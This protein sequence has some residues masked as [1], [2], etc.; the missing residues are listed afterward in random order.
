MP[1]APTP[2]NKEEVPC[3]S[4]TKHN[5][6]HPGSLLDHL[7]NVPS[8]NKAELSLDNLYPKY[9]PNPYLQDTEFQYNQLVRVN[10][11]PRVCGV[12]GDSTNVTTT[13]SISP[14]LMD[15]GA[16]ICITNKLELLVDIR[17][18]TPF[19][20]S[21]ATT[22]QTTLDG[23]CTMEGLLPL[24]L[25][26]GITI[27]V[28]TYY[29][30]DAAE[31][32]ISPELIVAS[33]PIYTTWSQTGYKDPT[34][35]GQLSLTNDDGTVRS[36]LTL[37]SKNNLYYCDSDVHT[38]Q[39]DILRS[40]CH[41]TYAP[42]TKAN[43]I[44]SELW[45]LRL[46]SPG[47]HQLDVL[48]SCA[49]GIPQK[50]A[51]HPFRSIDFKEQ[52]SIRKQP[53]TKQ[54]ERLPECG[55]E[56]YMDFGFMR[57][58]TSDYKKPN[59]QSDRVVLSHDGCCAYLII[60]DGKSRRLWAFT[61]KSK[62]PPI[63]LVRAFLAKFGKKSGGLIRTDQGG[64]LARCEEFR[65]VMETEFGY[66]VEPTGADS[67]SQNGAVE[68]Y[69]GVMGIRVR[70]LLYSSGLPAQFWSSALLHAAYLHNRQVHSATKMTPYEAWYGKRP[71]LAHLRVFGSRVCVRQPGERRCKLDRHDYSGIFLGYT[72]TD[73]NIIYLDTTSGIVKTS[74]HAVFD[75]SWYHQPKRPPAAQ[76]LYDIGLES[77]QDPIPASPDDTSIPEPVPAYPPIAP[78]TKGK[79]WNAPT[80]SLTAP[81]PLPSL[82]SNIISASA[83]VLKK[84]QPL[85]KLTGKQLA[86]ELVT[87]YLIGNNDTATIYM[88]PC[89][90]HQAFEEEL[91]LRK[92]DFSK[93]PTAGLQLFEKD[94]RVHLASMAPNSPGNKIYKWRTNVR[95]AWLMAIDNKQVTSISEVQSMIQQLCLSQAKSAV[96][97]FAHPEV[98]RDISNN[99][100]P[101]IH[102][103]DLSQAT[104]DQLNNRID[105]RLQRDKTFD[106]VE[107]GE[108][109]NITTKVMRL[110]RGKLLKQDDWEEWHQ[111]EYLQLD[112][113]D[114]QGMFGT[115]TAVSDTDSIF[116][117]VWTYN[118]KVVDGRKKARCV[119]DGSTRSGHVLVLDE[120]Y[121]NC[122]DQSSARLFYAVAA[123][124]N[125]LIFGADVSNAFAEA[126]PP[127]QGF[128]ILP[129]KA[130][131]DWWVYHK[132][133]PPIPPGHVI[134][135]NSAMQG[136][137]ES[138]R[139]WEKHVDS[140]LRDIGLTPTT[141][142]PCLYSGIINGERVILMRQVDDF[143]I[144]TQNADTANILLDEID[145]R[146]SIPLKRQGLIDIFNG[147]NVTQTK[148]Y[149]KIDCHTY[150]SKFCTKYCDSWMGNMHITEDRPTPLPTDPTW[151]RK[152]NAAEGSSDPKE[153]ARLSKQMQINYRAGVGELIWAMTT[154][155][156]DIGYAS[157]KLSQANS[158][159]HEHHYHG[160]KHAI[161]YLYATKDDGIYYWRTAARND[162][163]EGPPPRINSNKSDLLLQ[164]RPQHDATVAFAYADSDWAT[165]IKT[166]RSFTGACIFL[167]GGVIA[168]KTKFQLTVALSSTEAEFMAACD[169]GR[170]CLMIRSI[171]WDLDIPQEAA[172]ITYEDND[173]CTAMG[174]A[175]KPTSR[176]RH[177]DI[178]YFALCEW[179]ERDYIRL[180]R[181][182]T[183]INAADHLT[184]PLTRAL[185]HRHADYL[186]GHVPPKYS[187]VHESIV[188]TYNDKNHI[189]RYVPTVFTTPS[190]AKVNRIWSPTHLDI[191]GNPWLPILWHSEDYNSHFTV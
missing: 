131:H 101:I 187:P 69:N 174:N 154:C 84:P 18:I 175:Q 164:D 124:E 74:H 10:C 156:P 127:K 1:S 151:L 26:D 134:P 41:K 130:F 162:L 190:L 66:I 61:T 128:Y 109:R 179:I 85:T 99:G 31:T 29:C 185:F 25:D 136:H 125:H 157:V 89:P 81:L 3:A 9:H 11:S 59:K 13:A 60:V 115:P 72:A 77:V 12:L 27:Y 132:H 58:S 189:D 86:A 135:I 142:E 180:E 147:I 44:E 87:N 121:A 67:P 146:L 168:Y 46:G 177:I 68:I 75:E 83:A 184:K 17:H 65:S 20:F 169:V 42:V 79:Q 51:C 8:I 137:P 45:L 39:H 186:L 110:T 97:T 52:A 71:N 63:A 170:M 133:R 19:A 43:Q 111:A 114:D 32:I 148:H 158:K 21:V 113:Y 38:V 28:P 56:F 22:G 120:T 117:L 24:R 143:A 145:E 122:V 53:A 171:L 173:G 33:S 90:Y 40:A 64:E 138:P 37:H 73:K 7:H 15:S 54:A 116:H 47:E 93:H 102:V 152:F 183:S 150:I 36:T 129:D 23:C 95:G 107:S 62:N 98:S 104:L 126:P 96:L 6:Y 48:P 57:S 91:D 92:F 70:T 112:Q 139:L 141:H 94:K 82:H 50:F 178:K 2:N 123:A 153:Q 160:L 108:V 16:N 88:S 106:I 191:S 155:R 181:I 49:D 78:T 182:D 161:K 119:C 167:A 100:L 14:R 55:D 35:P 144:A 172:T 80:N 165:C 166:R 188:Q 159:P 176:T 34:R 149:V 140:I 105:I 103:E 76:L 163:P 30:K 4:S 118:V 5:P